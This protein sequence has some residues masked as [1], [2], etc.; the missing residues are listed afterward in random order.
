MAL[1]LT[2]G[3]LGLHIPKTG[4]SWVRE[5]LFN[6]GHVKVETRRVHSPLADFVATHE[7]A[8][9]KFTFVRHPLDWYVSYW[10]WQTDHGWRMELQIPDFPHLC[11]AD[12]TFA[13]F[14]QKCLAHHPA[15][16]SKLYTA[17][18]GPADA[19][20]NFIG[21]YESLRTGLIRLLTSFNLRW[22]DVVADETMPQQV[23]QT[24]K[25]DWPDALR[26]QVIVAEQEALTRFGYAV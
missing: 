15:L 24:T 10:R 12:E 20:I 7:L 19:P 22:D 6:L 8:A 1:L 4:G 23:S 13:G 2:N 3:A 17:Y 11:C 18:V 14:V 9:Y 26:Q 16:V 21:R 5:V 25:P